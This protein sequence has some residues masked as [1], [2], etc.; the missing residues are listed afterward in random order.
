MKN[1]NNVEKID[2]TKYTI[3]E[4]K[5]PFEAKVFCL[6]LGDV[7]SCIEEY[8]RIHGEIDGEVYFSGSRVGIVS[9]QNNPHRSRSETWKK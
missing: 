2:I 6:F 5:F 8:V 7:K 3:I 4:Q 9:S 1:K